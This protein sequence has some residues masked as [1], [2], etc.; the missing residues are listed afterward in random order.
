MA[1]PLD[2]AALVVSFV[3]AI[4]THPDAVTVGT[5]EREADTVIEV[6]VSQKDLGK[7]IGANGR[8][9]RALR[10]LL[11][12]MRQNNLGQYFLDIDAHPD[13]L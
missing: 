12:A 4:V 1:S 6:R 2:P 11:V 7:V 9:A 5:Y 10:I 8:T 3:R 13:Q